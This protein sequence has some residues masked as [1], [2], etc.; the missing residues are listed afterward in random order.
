MLVY[1]LAL[2][3]LVSVPLHERGCGLL[4]L[5]RFAGVVELPGKVPTLESS[6]PLP[7]FFTLLGLSAWVVAAD[8]LQGSFQCGSWQYWAS[9]LSVLIPVFT[10]L[11]VF[12]EVL[13]K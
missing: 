7:H 6:L 5:C 4:L 11:A 8:I 12:R 3:L 2:L 13:L 9:Q 1:K 10:I